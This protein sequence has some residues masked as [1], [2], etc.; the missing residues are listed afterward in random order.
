MASSAP[1]AGA[2]GAAP[3]AAHRPGRR[4]ADL[5]DWLAV[6]AGT[7]GALM[8]T[9]DISIVNSSLPTIQGSIGATGSEA[10][11]VATSFLVA[12]IIIIPL[13][14]W[15]TKLL[16]LRRFLLISAILFVVFSVICGIATNL[17]TM[18]IGRVGQGLSGGAM[19]PTAMTI[20]A[21][22][23]P[24]HQ[25]P[26][27]SAAFGFTAIMGPVVGP[28]LGGWLTETYSWHYA[29]FINVPLSGFLVALLLIGLPKSRARLDLLADADWLGLVGLTLFL[30]GF[31]LV[32]EEGNREQ[33]FQS[34][35]IIWL[36]VMATIGVAMVTAG[37][38]WAKEPII[39]L[40]LLYDRQ[41]SG[42]IV[43]GL[44]I[45]MVLYGSSF[46][47]PQFLA[48]ISNYNA[49]QAGMIVSITGLP[50]I[51][52]MVLSPFIMRIFDIRLAVGI[53]LALLV[54]SAWVDT[55]LNAESVGGDFVESQLLRGLGIAM[56][57]IFLNQAAISSVPVKYAGDAAGLFNTARNLGG[58]LAL[59]AIA[60]VQEQRYYFHARRLEE[61]LSAN[62]IAVQDRLLEMTATY[63]SSEAA[64][65]A[66]SGIISREALV[67]T[68]NDLF[69]LLAVV[70][71]VVIP[72]A[73]LLRPLPS[74][75]SSGPMH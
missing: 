44:A 45:G 61:T 68:Y 18:I 37:Q 19:I 52:L 42:V 73:L 54:L 64:L 30:G 33:W 67:M 55:T 60:T 3:S 5:S 50:A 1:P 48:A 63:G 9:L 58:S 32:L 7:L 65:R 56:T 59:A 17:T 16:G 62:A 46:V 21:T 22:R 4:N 23:L 47:I 51:T 34:A 71:V 66:L 2:S 36:T 13:S 12:E 69:F 40:S 14:G 74:D 70:I 39:R 29:F 35:E 26:I 8:A 25:Q 31:T 20:I 72:L 41:F 11:W 27:G 57:F 53:G 38:L 43:M 10:T 49:L 15:L 75:I 28:V 24:P 6:A